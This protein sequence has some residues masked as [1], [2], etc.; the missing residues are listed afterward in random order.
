[1]LAMVPGGLLLQRGSLEADFWG[2]LS[3]GTGLAIGTQY[4]QLEIHEMGWQ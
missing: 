2:I 4:N 1:M 3:S